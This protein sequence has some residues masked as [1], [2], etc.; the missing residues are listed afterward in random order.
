MEGPGAAKIVTRA[1]R[2]EVLRNMRYNL[3]TKDWR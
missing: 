3:D 1:R 2:Y